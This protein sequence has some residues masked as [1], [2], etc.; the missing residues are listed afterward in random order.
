MVMLRCRPMPS[1]TVRWSGSCGHSLARWQ[2]RRL[3]RRAPLEVCKGK[4]FPWGV[5]EEHVPKGHGIPARMFNAVRVSLE[6]KI[7]SVREQ[8]KLQADRLWRRI[9]R[10]ELQ[11]P[12]LSP[13]PHSLPV[14]FVEPP[15]GVSDVVVWNQVHQKRRR[16]AN[17]Q[18]RLAQLES[19]IAASRVRLC[20]GSKK[21][22]RKQHQRGAGVVGGQVLPGGQWLR[23]P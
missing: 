20:F 9:A 11:L 16:L 15:Q 14:L 2:R 23:Q 1:C 3:G 5:V 18:H 19:D 12:P 17:L 13:R 4:A 8:Q 21:L 10:A 7:A 22:W 6:G